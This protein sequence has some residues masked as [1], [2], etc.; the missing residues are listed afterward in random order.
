MFVHEIYHII[1]SD[2]MN[3]FQMNE[4]YHMEMYH[5]N[6]EVNVHE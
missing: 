6:V 3:F 2:Q 5:M 1:E 4:N